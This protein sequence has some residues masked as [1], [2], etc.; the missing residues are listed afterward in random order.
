ML[1][2]KMNNSLAPKNTEIIF[3]TSEWLRI[4]F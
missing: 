2:K 4:E 1:K 3:F